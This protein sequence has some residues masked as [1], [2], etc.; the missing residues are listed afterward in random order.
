LVFFELFWIFCRFELESNA[1]AWQ[2][3]QMCHAL[4]QLNII[5]IL[6]LVMAVDIPA[7]KR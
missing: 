4:H 6:L 5:I 3:Q 1:F 2:A 7:R